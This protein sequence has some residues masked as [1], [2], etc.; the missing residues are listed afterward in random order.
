MRPRLCENS[1][2]FS[3]L[4]NVVFRSSVFSTRCIVGWC[5]QGSCFSA[6]MPKRKETYSFVD[7][8]K[9]L[10]KPDL[11]ALGGYNGA[12]SDPT[13]I[14]PKVVEWAKH[15]CSHKPHFI[16]IINN[17]AANGDPGHMFGSKMSRKLTVPKPFVEENFRELKRVVT[18]ENEEGKKW[19]VS[20]GEI[21]SHPSW[22]QGWRR[23]A[24]DYDLQAGE[25]I[26]FVLV[27]N[28]HFRFT[29]FDENGNILSE[30]KLGTIY[31][32]SQSHLIPGS[33]TN[34]EDK[35]H[36]RTSWKSKR[37]AALASRSSI[38][39]FLG[40]AELGCQSSG[41]GL[42]VGHS[43]EALNQRLAPADKQ[44]AEDICKKRRLRKVGEVKSE[45]DFNDESNLA[46]VN[47]HTHDSEEAGSM[48]TADSPSNV[49]IVS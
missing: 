46:I 47:E 31:S 3:V 22:Q 26:V 12:T 4:I 2:R 32:T 38:D 24:I 7:E 10:W 34:S 29:R 19:K 20:F 11:D 6:T 35:S 41:S 42:D 27:A 28:S 18:L 5:D 40:A 33:I 43:R 1:A 14:D 45:V 48:S 39:H 49:T 8:W 30:K 17:N 36:M 25:V 37:A 15:N 16:K 23:L 44:I 21:S 9:S 13:R